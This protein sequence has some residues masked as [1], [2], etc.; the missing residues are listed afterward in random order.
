MRHGFV[1]LTIAATSAW[2]AFGAVEGQNTVFAHYMTCFTLTVPDVKREIL[3]A[4]QY[5]IDGWALNCGNWKRQDPKTGEWKPF[6]GYVE[7]STRCF[8]AAEELGTGFKFFFSPDGNLHSYTNNFHADMLLMWKDHPNHFRYG[9]R[10]L[11]SGWG[12]GNL[13]NEKYRFAREDLNARGVADFLLVPELGPKRNV[14]YASKDLA[15]RQVYGDPNFM[16][17]GQFIFGCD[18]TSRELAE[19]LSNGRFAAL[20]AGK[21][22]MAGPCPAYDSSN[23][24][25]YHGLAGYASEW[26]GI[27]A[28]QPELIEVVTWNDYAED[29]G[30]MPGGP[31]YRPRWIANRTFT[32]RDESYLDLTAYYAAAYKAGG[33]CPKIVQ[34]KIYTAYR[35][36]PKSM[37]RVYR[38]DPEKGPKGPRWMDLR[39]DYLQIHDDVLDCVYATVMLTEPADVTIRQTI[40]AAEGKS[41]VSRRMPAGVHTLEAPMVRGA[42]PEFVVSRNGRKVLEVAGRRQ[43]AAR[44]T[45]RNSHA[46]GWDG[47]HR[48]WSGGSVAGESVLTLAADAEGNTEWAL[49]ADFKPG[50]YN[51]RVRYSNDEE[52]ESRY[53]I[54]VDVPWMQKEDEKAMPVMLP[55]YLPPTGGRVL[56]QGFLLSVMPGATG[57]RIARD[58]VKG[59]VWAYNNGQRYLSD[60]DYSDYGT[61][62][63][64]SVAL[65][66][67]AVAKAGAAPRPYPEMVA[68]PGGT[69]TMGA[70]AIEPDEGGPR[71]VTVSPFSIGKYE[72]TN[73]EF[74]EFMPEHRSHRT[75][76]SWRD[77]DPVIYVS[78]REAADYCN[79]LSS[80]EGLA[81]AYDAANDYA[82]VKGSRGY[83]LP[84]EAEWEYVASGRGE[85][86]VYP[87]GGEP[88]TYELCNFAPAEVS[89]QQEYLTRPAREL[90]TAPV[91]SYPKGVSRDGVHDLAGNVCEW[92]TDRYHYDVWP[93]GQDP[94]DETPARSARQDFRAIRGGSF[95]YYGMSQRVCDREFNNPRYQGYIYIGFRVAKPE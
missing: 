87:W 77:R 47:I 50:S 41:V 25:D 32:Q 81:P 43:I 12:G 7:K 75:E 20:Q 88:P 83:R 27:C 90:K 4:Q 6:D 35:S 89:L 58:D 16:C 73:R 38:P 56:E 65:V 13:K 24:R 44:E 94:V 33:V 45:I 76:L 1:C 23:L 19:V 71:E 17:D 39:D 3:L 28:D 40:G 92:C 55:L 68:I 82:L 34:D 29:S 67:N 49:P 48:V 42:T 18:N 54:Y 46:L 63:V 10:P 62:R 52:E 72:V 70:N 36:R 8:K 22:F 69:F 91:G 30:L 51:F 53:T 78:W 14:M 59:Q 15:A 26:Q 64:L 80:K 79:W 95:G 37:T 5:G 60:F 31:D 85:N 11:F 21:L 2:T 9:G 86:R 61:A 66:P 93:E 74:E 84:T 57:I